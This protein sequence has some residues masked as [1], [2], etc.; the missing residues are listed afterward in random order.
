MEKQKQFCTS[1]G[2]DKDNNIPCIHQT[3]LSIIEIIVTMILFMN[4]PFIFFLISYL[5]K[6]QDFDQIKHFWIGN[7][8]LSIMMIIF[9]IANYLLKKPYLAIIFGCH[10]RLDR[11]FK[12]ILRNWPLCQRC[13][14]IYIGIFVCL[15]FSYLDILKEWMI[16][17]ALPLLIDGWIQRKTDYKSNIY[18]RMTTGVLFS[19]LLVIVFGWIQKLYLVFILWLS[20]FFISF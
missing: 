16:L 6:N 8:T 11:S 9:L 12:G 19:P 7:Y 15:M 1:C 5:S 13:T 4:I 2:R 20:S 18:R 17:F 14:G 10:Q 3:S